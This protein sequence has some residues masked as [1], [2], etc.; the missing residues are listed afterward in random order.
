[1]YIN[2]PPHCRGKTTHRSNLRIR[3]FRLSFRAFRVRVRSLFPPSSSPSLSPLFALTAA[4]IYT[5][6]NPHLTWQNRPRLATVQRT[7]QFLMPPPSSPPA[8][9]LSQMRPTTRKHT[10]LH[11]Q[12]L[13]LT[14]R[15]AIHPKL[16]SPLRQILYPHL[17][18]RKMLRLSICLVPPHRRLRPHPLKL[19]TQPE[20]PQKPQT[21][22]R[23]VGLYIAP[24]SEEDA[25]A[26]AKSDNPDLDS[27]AVAKK[28]TALS[29]AD[30]SHATGRVLPHRRVR[31]RSRRSHPSSRCPS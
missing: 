7:L 2:S 23:P 3:S 25:A 30:D 27:E 22:I 8:L 20:Q 12:K 1:M 29:G 14:L 18:L 15:L 21:R 4:V 17:S 6:N 26:A 24:S 10:K 16:L 31:T 19:P 5:I 11:L 28:P 9:A 13:K